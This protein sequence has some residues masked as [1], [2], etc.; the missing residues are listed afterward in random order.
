MIQLGWH[1]DLHTPG[2]V[3]VNHKPDPSG[4]ANALK[5][6]GVDEIITFAKCHF[7]HAYY[8][9]KVGTPHPRM[10]G[11]ALAGVIAACRKVGIRVLAY[12]SFGIDGQA[13]V[14]HPEWCQ[15]GKAGNVLGSD[16]FLCV[17]PFTA[18]LDELMLPQIEEV[19]ERY[20][21]DGLWFDTMSALA[22]CF[23]ETCRAS[24]R[25]ATEK[26]IPT[27]DKGP[28]QAGYGRWRHGRG[29][30]MVERVCAFI[31]QRL[32]GATVSFNQ[33]G[34]VC[35]PEPLPKGVT[36]LSLDP[37]TYGPQSVQY[38]LNAMFGASTGQPCEVMPTIF[39]QGWGDWSAASELR[40]ESVAVSVWARGARLFMGDRL[41]PHIRLTPITQRALKFV[42]KLRNRVQAEFPTAEARLAPDIVIVH[43][44]SVTYGDEFEDFARRPR[45]RLGRVGGAHELCLDAGLNY[46]VAGE[47]FLQPW[48]ERARAVV[49]PELNRIEEDTGRQLHAF[50]QNGGRLLIVGIVPIAGEK[51]LD[52]VGVRVRAE[53]W[54][55][56]IYLPAWSAGD[57]LPTLVRGDFHP[58]QLTG[59]KCVLRVIQ[60][61]D[62]RH[63]KRYGWGIGPACDEPSRHPVLTRHKLGR[64]EVWYLGARLFSDYARHAN[65]QQLA[66]FAK[67]AR[68]MKAACRAWIDSAGGVELVWWEN[69]R[70][71]WAILI[72]HGAEQ[73]CGTHAMPMPWTRT[74]QPVPSQEVVLHVETR[75]RVPGRVIAGGRRIPGS[76]RAGRLRV[77]LR[78]DSLWR[79]VRVDWR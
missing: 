7:G 56:H 10:K 15:R 76:G 63:G 49:L 6:A 34:S 29:V 65:W 42:G 9:T 67:F 59:A 18:Y 61:F 38:S 5:V 44:P 40:W 68:Q 64:G 17:C 24:F 3:R 31:H 16:G 41:H 35:Y 74:M 69:T 32:P 45:E 39:N 20:R 23:C 19:I 55:D 36:V 21:P 57:E 60:G 37:P 46:T 22:P 43:N 73:L 66:W 51:P 62:A 8:P 50:V 78:L 79:V 11:D 47:A 26:E 28:L 58:V 72:Q 52:W 75:G 25:K 30:A 48:L 27:D 54:Q 2:F 53:P 70:S 77:P 14:K 71:S 13:G 33:L 1:F 4:M 12:I